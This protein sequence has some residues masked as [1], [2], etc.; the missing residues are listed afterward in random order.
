MISFPLLGEEVPK[1]Y[2]KLVKLLRNHILPLDGG[3]S[4]WG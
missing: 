4:R 2:V 1:A 3:G